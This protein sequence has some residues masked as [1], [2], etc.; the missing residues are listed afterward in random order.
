M[1]LGSIS[2]LKFASV[3]R[4]T[5][6]K[7]SEQAV[8]PRGGTG[9]RRGAKEEKKPVPGRDPQGKAECTGGSKSL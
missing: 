4:P 2:H 3:F 6:I 8:M 5:W 1:L 7:G 9:P